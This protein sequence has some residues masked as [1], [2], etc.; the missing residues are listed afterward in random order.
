MATVSA[1]TIRTLTQLLEDLGDVEPTRVRITCGRPA[2]LQDV[3]ELHDRHKILC[4][5]VDGVLVEK[6][7]GGRAS[8]VAMMLVYYL[9]AYLLRNPIGFLFGPDGPLRIADDL[10]R[11][12]DISFVVWDKLPDRTVPSEPIPELVP[13]LAVE[14]LSPSN[15]PGEIQ[16]KRREYFQAGTRLVWVV[17]PENRT[18]EVASSLDAVVTLHKAERLDGGEILPEFSIAVSDLFINI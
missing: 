4:E 6:V 7:M 11:I 3:I 2:G 1:E 15:R 5:L 10:V 9:N 16:R 8:H 12:P 17:D 14:V 18:V 13:D